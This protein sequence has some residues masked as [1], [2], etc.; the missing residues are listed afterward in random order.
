MQLPRD[1]AYRS[2]IAAP[3][4]CELVKADPSLL[5]D[6]E[7]LVE[8]KAEIAL[9]QR[10]IEGHCERI[11]KQSEL[12]SPKAEKKADTPTVVEVKAEIR[13]ASVP[14]G[15]V[16]QVL[17]G[18]ATW[19]VVRADRLDFLNSLPADSMDLFVTSPPYEGQ[20]TYGIDFD[21]QGEA[22]VRWM[23]DT[24]QAALR[25][26]KGLVAVVCEGETKNFSYS[27]VPYLLMADLVRAGVVVRKPLIY[28]RVGIPGS[29]S[30]DWL[31]ADFE[32]ILCC[33]R[34]GRLPWSYNM[35]MGH[36]P[37]Y[38]PGGKSSHHR[39]DGSRVGKNAPNGAKDGD[40]RHDRDYKPPAK[41]NP[42]SV[43]QE[44]YA[45]Q[46]VAELLSKHEAGDVIDWS[47]GGNRIGDPLAHE[48]EAP[49]PE[50]LVEFLVRSFCPPGSVV[51]DCYSGSGTTGA[52][53]VRLGRRF[54]GCDLRDSQVSL[55]KQRIARVLENK[56]AGG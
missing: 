18:Q 56:A 15:E 26:C 17:S 8:A 19:A 7:H 52:V 23:F 32:P 54:V 10:Q 37:K 40:T 36:M 29:G 28:R 33:T 5:T 11:F 14:A 25:V 49:F 4:G 50:R 20:R 47:V 34:G 21:L 27:A 44:T 38:A 13:S 48:N 45:A 51:A 31:R 9:L 42:G 53:A 55:S 22:W 46:E 3:A 1:K 43:I 30:V 6:T 24:V 39:K 16:A 12:L 41:A 35:A 2:A